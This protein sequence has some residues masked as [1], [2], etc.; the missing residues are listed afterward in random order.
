MIAGAS[1]GILC[2][3]RS[4]WLWLALSACAAAPPPDPP[5]K[6]ESCSRPCSADDIN[7]ATF[8][9]E[10]LPHRCLDICYLGTCCDLVDGAWVTETF[11][12]ARPSAEACIAARPASSG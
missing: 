10:Q 6:P 7:C 3:M 9:Y 8:P 1:A 11:D 2:A 4:A 12:C 5:P